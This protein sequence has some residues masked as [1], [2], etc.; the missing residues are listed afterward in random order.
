MISKKTELR[1]LI[2]LIKHKTGLTQAELADRAGYKRTYISQALGDKNPPQKLIDKLKLVFAE[3]LQSEHNRTLPKQTPPVRAIQPQ[4]GADIK[5]RYIQ[6]LEEKVN[7]G[8]KR[9]A[10]YAMTN[11][12]LLKTVVQ[13]LAVIQS[14]LDK[15]KLSEVQAE[16]NN[17]VEQHLQALRKEGT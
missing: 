7:S 2:D 5:D 15:R 3:D 4:G 10:L 13:N 1:Q 17:Q 8:D 16:M 11:Q 9:V 14:K 6:V 12:A